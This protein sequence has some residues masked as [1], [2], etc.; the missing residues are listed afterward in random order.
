MYTQKLTV[1]FEQLLGREQLHSRNTHQEKVG[2]PSIIFSSPAQIPEPKHQLQ[3]LLHVFSGVSLYWWQEFALHVYI[4]TQ[5]SPRSFV[6]STD[7]I[8]SAQG[9]NNTDSKVQ[10]EGAPCTTRAC[11]CSRNLAYSMQVQCAH[12]A[13]RFFVCG[14]QQEDPF[15]ESELEKEA[16]SMQSRKLHVGCMCRFQDLLFLTWIKESSHKCWSFPH[17]LFAEAWAHG[18]QATTALKRQSASGCEIPTGKTLLTEQ[19]HEDCTRR[20][21]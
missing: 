18:W 11:T 6:R 2:L 17:L 19:K 21:F 13:A 20:R 10:T 7:D 9:E 12:S 15:P 8:C 1:F 4:L 3:P 14:D 5:P 16:S